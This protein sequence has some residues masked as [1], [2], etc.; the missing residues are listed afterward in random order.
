MTLPGQPPHRIDTSR[1]H[2]ARLYDYYLDGKDNYPVDWEAAEKVLGINPHMRTVAQANRA[3][4]HRSTRWLATKAGIRQFLDIGT[5]IPT[6][7]NLHQVAQEAAPDAR[8]AYADNDP[9]VLRHA[10]ALMTST[11]QGRTA[12]LHADVTDP[13][14]I[15][16]NE[17]LSTVL[18]LR[19]PVALS[20]NALLHFV[21]DDKRPYDI[22]QSLVDALAPGSY[23][24]L[25]HCTGDFL[26]DVWS[27]LVD[28]Y[29]EQKIGAQV[30]T[31]EEVLRFFDGLELMEPGL[32]VGH[33]WKPDQPT[34]LTD[35][36]VSLY[37]AV[38]LKR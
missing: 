3:F 29:A 11:E 37:A 21:P 16:G 27:Q 33:R 26:P 8:I 6:Q 7:P 36:E 12:Y 5:G 2:S 38:A 22:V 25:S 23:L 15:L 13:Q 9:I 34:G 17:E 32:V 30:R 24:V 18:D 14:S 10:E 31:K 20:L 35:A 28:I 19:R 1:A 4:M